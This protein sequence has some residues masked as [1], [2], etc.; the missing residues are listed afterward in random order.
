MLATGDLRETQPPGTGHTCKMFRW[1]ELLEL[2]NCAGGRVLAA[3]ASNWASLGDPAA[4][5]RLVARPERWAR[6]LDHEVRLWGE[7]GVLD[8]STHILFAAA[9]Q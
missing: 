1:P 3:S 6:F 5:Q 8:G 7:P 2:V 4:L 9:S